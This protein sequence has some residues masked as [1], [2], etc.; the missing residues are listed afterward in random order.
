MEDEH[1]P[2][3]P[4][5]VQEIEAAPATELGRA[6]LV[7][8]EHIVHESSIKSLG[9]LHLGC[10]GLFLL[11]ALVGLVG[12]VSAV[13]GR[14]PGIVEIGIVVGLYGGIGSMLLISGYGLRT[15]KPWARVFSSVL[16]GIGLLGFPIG[17]LVNAY[18][19]WLLLSAKGSTILGPE[20]RYVVT[21]TPHVK[22]TPWAAIVLLVL[23]L[24]AGVVFFAA[25][26]V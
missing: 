26:R 20:Y 13:S 9:C 16:C 25:V 19:L 24:V 3:A 2:Y 6:E 14:G 15:L 21:A 5:E 18:C 12:V 7:R 10:G 17:T 4:P 22:Y 1:N 8:R 11:T 23:I